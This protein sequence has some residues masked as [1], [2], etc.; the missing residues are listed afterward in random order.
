M[1]KVDVSALWKNGWGFGGVYDWLEITEK[2]TAMI[3]YYSCIVAHVKA[4]LVISAYR[5]FMRSR[6][7][8]KT[9]QSSALFLYQIECDPRDSFNAYVNDVARTII[10]WVWLDFTKSVAKMINV[11]V[12]PKLK[13]QCAASAV[14]WLP[15]VLIVQAW[16]WYLM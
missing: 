11:V 4:G 14:F 5:W 7:A 9:M 13:P 10:Q 1:R 12:K 6:C 15:T 3:Y 8:F 2:P 16:R